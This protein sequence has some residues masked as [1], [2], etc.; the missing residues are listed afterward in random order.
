MM[1]TQWTD[2]LVMRSSDSVP[3]GL[4]HV[5]RVSAISLGLARTHRVEK[6]VGT[7]VHQSISQ[8]LLFVYLFANK[9]LRILQ[10]R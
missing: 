1:G 6:F 10:S 9:N 3:L 8:Y 7:M 5:C 4:K 2:G